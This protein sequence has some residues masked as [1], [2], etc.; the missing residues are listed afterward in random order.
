MCRAWRCACSSGPTDRGPSSACGDSGWRQQCSGAIRAERGALGMARLLSVNVGLPRDIEWRGKTVHTGIWKQP[1]QGR[2]RVRRLN[3]EGD[4]QG[5]LG[6]HG[7]EQ[8]AGFVYQIESAR[9]WAERLGRREFSHGQFVENFTI[10]GL[11]DDE[12]CI[13]DRYRIGSALFEV[14]Q[15]R[16]TCYRVGIR[17]DEPLMAALLTSSGRPGFYLRV[18]EE[19]EVGAGDLILPHCSR[20]RAHDRR[21]GQCAALSLSPSSRAARAGASNSCALPWLAVVVRGVA[22]KPEGPS[23]GHGQRGSHARGGRADR[24][25]RIPAAEDLGDRSRMHRRDLVVAAADGWKAPHEPTTGAIRRAP[26]ATCVR[27]SSALPELLTLRPPLRRAVP[28]ER[29]GRAQRSRG[30][31]LEQQRTTGR[32]P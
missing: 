26:A 22:S 2:R 7:G 17:L 24:G 4:G 21:R 10:E 29:Q 16:T 14:T 13:G 23:G 9:Y 5:D 19:G 25:A 28:G 6:G 27:W 3:V 11:P 31:L 1:V 18:L 15:P 30:N 12:V 32:R 8:R 20:T